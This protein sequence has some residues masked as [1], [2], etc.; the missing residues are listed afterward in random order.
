MLKMQKSRFSKTIYLIRHGQTK[1]NTKG[2]WLGSRS[3]D[4]LSEYGRKQAQDT[5]RILEQSDINASKIF[6]SP[7]PRALEHAEIIQKQLDLPIDKIHSLTEINLGIL[8]DRTR[9]QG[10]KLVP[11]E[12][13]DWNTKLTEFEPPLGESAV[14]AAE[15]FYEIVEL[16]AKNY[17]KP[18]LIIVSHGVVIKLFLAR[19]FKES[20]ETAETKIN[21]PWTKHGT[22]TVAKF[23]GQGFKFIKVI[24]NKYPD[25]KQV[26]EFG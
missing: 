14:E 6:S 11:E 21:V 5:A 17:Q 24:E 18:D 12:I 10:L 3:I 4:K 20:I 15:R 16:I 25:S 8:E 13:H 1:G 19:I 23:D 9:E 7:T 22:I 26:A 2:N